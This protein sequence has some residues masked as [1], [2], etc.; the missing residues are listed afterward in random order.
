MD[1]LELIEAINKKIQLLEAQKEDG[2]KDLNF[3]LQVAKNI[4]DS[5][6]FSLMETNLFELILADFKIEHQD[7]NLRK[8]KKMI[9]PFYSLFSKIDEGISF[10]LWSS[11]MGIIEGHCLESFKQ[12]L[13]EKSSLKS[14]INEYRIRKDKN[15][16]EETKDD[17]SNIIE[18]QETYSLETNELIKAMEFMKCYMH[19]SVEI[20]N[21]IN[22]VR[23][24][25]RL[26][27]DFDKRFNANKTSTTTNK[28]D[29]IFQKFVSS[30]IDTKEFTGVLSK[31]NQYACETEKE[32]KSRLRK[33]EK[34]IR[35]YKEFLVNFLEAIKNKEI[36]NYKELIS[37]IADDEL[38]LEALKIIYLHNQSYYQ[39]LD[40]EY[41]MISQNSQLK[42][43][44]LLSKYDLKPGEYKLEKILRLTYEEINEML[45]LTVRMLFDKELIIY[46][47]ENSDL[48]KLKIIS[49]Y[50]RRDILTSKFIKLYP[51]ILIDSDINERLISNISVLEENDI[52]PNIFNKS[53]NILLMDKEI[54]RQKINIL[55]KYNLLGSIKTTNNYAFL[56]DND[57]EKKIDKYLEL[58]LEAFL[59][60]NLDLLNKSNIERLYAIKF[61]NLPITNEETL[62]SYLKEENYFVKDDN[63]DEYLP[64]VV[65]YKVDDE[66]YEGINIDLESFKNTERT[67]AINGHL[68]SSN[69]V[70]RNL[71]KLEN[72]D[73]PLEKK[74]KLAILDG[75]VLSEKDYQEVMGGLK[76]TLTK[77]NEDEGNKS[78]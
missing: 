34:T 46:V 73:M 42:I 77:A 9:N 10:S 19:E 28:K 36:S 38:K 15:I 35:D 24:T 67:Y 2:N 20:L 3:F 25:K 72:I 45:R 55:K 50:V 61:L 6:L 43:Q 29:K 39:Q 14:L 16:S 63:L 57:L 13:L 41:E 21:I 69:K 70:K 27:K 37:K 74:V 78:M 48:K 32:E 47:L 33:I 64:N 51:Q 54:F 7:L 65:G 59:V 40:E 30:S 52:N 12:L 53:L 76:G 62:F 18:I 60:Q 31:V 22:F 75:L 1:K 26:K 44:D 56:E 5:S 49:E 4:T 58:G 8:I 17:I 11:M 68:V 71:K 23:V 66:D